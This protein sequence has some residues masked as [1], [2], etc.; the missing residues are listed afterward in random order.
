MRR[1]FRPVDVVLNLLP[2]S[3]TIDKDLFDTSIG[4]KL[5]SV[6]DKRG[7]CEWQQTLRYCQYKSQA[8]M[9]EVLTL[10]RSS[11]KGLKRVSKGSARIYVVSIASN[12]MRHRTYH[13]LERIL[14]LLLAGLA[15][16]LAFL[17]FRWHFWLYSIYDAKSCRDALL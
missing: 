16:V 12:R 5:E 14:A 7:V 9:A 13:S 4:E 2:V 11:V 10:G 1:P 17:S 3:T 15:F 8:D 6:F